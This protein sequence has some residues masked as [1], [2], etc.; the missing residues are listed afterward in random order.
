MCC[1][2]ED[3]PELETTLQWDSVAL[4][5]CSLTASLVAHRKDVSQSAAPFQGVFQLPLLDLG[6]GRQVAIG[7]NGKGLACVFP[8]QD[9]AI[10]GTSLDCKLS[11]QVLSFSGEFI[12]HGKNGQENRNIAQVPHL[13][14]EPSPWPLDFSR[15]MSTLSVPLFFFQRI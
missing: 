1:G 5:L 9:G 6:Q 12:W 8:V 4:H 2:C 10:T 11:S 7:R 13:Y 3:A 14:V 15:R